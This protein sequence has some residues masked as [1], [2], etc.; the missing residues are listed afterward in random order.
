MKTFSR[1]LI[2]KNET[3]LKKCD[4][5]SGANGFPDDGDAEKPEHNRRNR[6]DEFDV[7]FDESS[8]RCGDAISLT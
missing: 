5:E 8:S 1:S 7:R 2:G 4:C 6:G 3:Q